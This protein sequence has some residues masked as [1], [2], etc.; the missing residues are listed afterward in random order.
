[1]FLNTCQKMING[2]GWLDDRHGLS[3]NPIWH[4]SL[5][6][7]INYCAIVFSFVLMFDNGWLTGCDGFYDASACWLRHMKQ[8]TINQCCLQ[9]RR[10]F[11]FL[12]CFSNNLTRSQLLAK[13][14]YAKYKI[15]QRFWKA[16]AWIL[17]FLSV[18]EDWLAW[19]ILCEFPKLVVCLFLD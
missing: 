9:N 14:W 19:W 16:W 6:T 13:N 3:P 12:S 11:L 15:L 5:S 8:W 18:F 17:L 7:L 4:P 10:P 2:V 1:L